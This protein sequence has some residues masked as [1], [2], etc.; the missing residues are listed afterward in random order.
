MSQVP[1]NAR[2][3]EKEMGGFNQHCVAVAAGGR[4]LY[5]LKKL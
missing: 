1:T 2:A 3:W 4:A 5:V